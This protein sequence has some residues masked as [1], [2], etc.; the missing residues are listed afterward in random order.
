MFTKV[1]S[2]LFVMFSTSLHANDSPATVDGTISVDTQKAKELYDQKSPRVVFI[3]VRAKSEFEASSI[4]GAVLID[5]KALSDEDFEKA[6]AAAT[7]NNKD[8]PVFFFCNGASCP[9]SAIAAEKAE[10]LKYK[11][12]YY[13]REGFPAWANAGYAVK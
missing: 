10:K 12:I 4:V 3:D 11:T 6:M 1:L 9:K 2:I 7:Q 8:V 13:Y 5:L